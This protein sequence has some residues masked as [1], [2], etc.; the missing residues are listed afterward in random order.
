MSDSLRA[1][2]LQPARLLCPW[3]SPGKDTGAGH[4]MSCSRGSSPPRNR[5]RVSYVSLHCQGGFFNTSATQEAPKNTVNL[6]ST[7]KPIQHDQDQ[8]HLLVGGNFLQRRLTGRKLGGP[9]CSQWDFSIT[10]SSLPHGLGAAT[11][12]LHGLALGTAV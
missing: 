11:G 5:P 4:G 12:W 10:A 7:V 8:M 3:G 9:A 1:H 2:G 6:K